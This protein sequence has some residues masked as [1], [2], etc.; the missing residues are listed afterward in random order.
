MPPEVERPLDEEYV[1]QWVPLIK[2]RA[3]TLAE[4]TDL[5]LFFYQENLEYEPADLIIKGIDHQLTYNAYQQAKTIIEST[6]FKAVNLEKVFRALADE[7]KLKPGQ[8]FSSL[9]IAITGRTVSPPLFETMEAL[10]KGRVQD[11]ISDAIGKLQKMPD[12]GREARYGY[13]P[14]SG[15]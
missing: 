5:V 15:Y 12:V 10:G 8:L 14:T 7:L 11:R 1:R 3:K 13:Y 6:P 9:R 2:E 4:V